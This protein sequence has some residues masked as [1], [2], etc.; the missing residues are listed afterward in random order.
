MGMKNKSKIDVYHVKQSTGNVFWPDL[1][2]NRLRVLTNNT[3]NSI[4]YLLKKS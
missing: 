1:G 3:E 2:M 4:I